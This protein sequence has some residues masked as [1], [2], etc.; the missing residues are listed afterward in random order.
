MLFFV[1]ALPLREAAPDEVLGAA[2]LLVPAGLVGPEAL[3]GL[4]EARLAVPAAFLAEL[5]AFL[6][7]PAAFPAELAAFL[8]GP[9]AFLV[10]GPAAV[11]AE[12]VAVLA[13]LGADREPL[14]PLPL[15]EVPFDS[16]SELPRRFRLPLPCARFP[17]ECSESVS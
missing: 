16:C 14:E 1:A 12:R 9:A 15:R 2:F 7:G 11:L 3:R 17:F 4:V 8:T 10:A 5:A 6:A 13:A